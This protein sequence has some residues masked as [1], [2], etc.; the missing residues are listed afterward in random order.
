MLTDAQ[1]LTL[2]T[3][4]LAD[5]TFATLPHNT[6]GAYAIAEAY[7]TLSSPAFIVWRTDVPAREIGNAWSGTDVDG[8]SSLN[9]Q[10][11][12]LLL[13]S[14]PNGV[15][16]MSRIDR[17]AGFLNPFGTSQVNPS[18]VAMLV[19]FKRTANRLEKLFA[20]GTGSDASPATMAVEG[21]LAYQ[22]IQTV[23]GW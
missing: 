2:K 8:M 10:R 17:R 7:K 6:D 4:I 23:M 19:A 14:A 20:S 3:D 15:F 16:D 1:K 13:A 11:L 22:E 18:R 12:Q 5:P 9:M 21:S